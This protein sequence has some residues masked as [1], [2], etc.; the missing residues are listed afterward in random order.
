MRID[1]LKLPDYR[2]LKN[3]E[4]DFDETQATTVILGRN[5]SGKSNLIEALVEIFRDLEEGKPS[6]FAYEIKYLCHSRQVVVVN[7]PKAK[8][9]QQFQ[10][11]GVGLS[12]EEFSALSDEVLPKHVFAYYSGWNRRLESG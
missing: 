2:N 12:R 1:W 5:G 4:I 6:K 10:V 11:D 9:R 3:F 8:K 7:D